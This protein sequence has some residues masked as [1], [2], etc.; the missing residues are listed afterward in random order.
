MKNSVLCFQPLEYIDIVAA[1]TD[2]GATFHIL[3]PEEGGKLNLSL[4]S[5]ARWHYCIP[6]QILLFSA[7][8][9]KDRAVKRCCQAIMLALARDMDD[10][11]MR[12]AL[13][14]S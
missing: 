1:E 3:G 7:V 6:R 12:R 11:I 8:P 9:S 14:A 2:F 10:A 5:L 4:R 13:M